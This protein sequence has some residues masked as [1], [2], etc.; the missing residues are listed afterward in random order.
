M[1]CCEKFYNEESA[2]EFSKTITWKNAEVEIDKTKEPNDD[3]PEKELED[4]W[5][6][7]FNPKPLY[8]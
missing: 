3:E 2:I 8:R 5:V 4:I 7:W 1:K 6:V